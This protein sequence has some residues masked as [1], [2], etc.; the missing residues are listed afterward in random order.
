MLAVS[1][2]AVVQVEAVH[3]GAGRSRQLVVSRTR[4]LTPK[5]GPGV[6]E[7]RQS[8]RRHCRILQTHRRAGALL[9][10]NFTTLAPTWQKNHGL[11]SFV[12]RF[13]TAYLSEPIS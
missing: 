10:L 6:G 4:C 2:R 9:P 7:G 1:S 12:Y 3:L 13:L 8:P 5:G 11:L